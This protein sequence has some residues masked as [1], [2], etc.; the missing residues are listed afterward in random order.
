MESYWYRFIVGK[1][2][3]FDSTSE[4]LEN[5]T[6]ESQSTFWWPEDTKAH[7]VHPRTLHLSNP[8]SALQPRDSALD[9]HVISGRTYAPFPSIWK[10]M[11]TILQLYYTYYTLN[12]KYVI[13]ITMVYPHFDTGPIVR[14]FYTLEHFSGIM[15]SSGRLLPW[16]VNDPPLRHSSDLNLTQGTL[17]R[18]KPHL[19]YWLVVW[20]P[21]KNISQL[22]W[23]FWI[24][25]K[26]W[27]MFQTTNNMVA[28]E[29][30][31][32]V[33]RMLRPVLSHLKDPKVRRAIAL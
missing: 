29:K 26:I 14:L 16:T 15:A 7:K 5:H 27:F 21:P 12:S 31:D 9:L 8:S 22:G 2:S 32:S 20:T 4:F 17:N 25:G 6:R 18:C 3:C 10:N 13:E 30:W 24:Y 28:P 23:L 19:R 11:T 1:R 33:Q